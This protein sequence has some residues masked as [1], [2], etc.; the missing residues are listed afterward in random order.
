MFHIQL[1]SLL[2]ILVVYT[3]RRS[4]HSRSAVS[5]KRFTDHVSLK[6]MVQYYL[7][8]GIISRT[9]TDLYRVNLCTKVLSGWPWLFQKKIYEMKLSRFVF[10]T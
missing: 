5:S 4:F 10:Q 2:G 7:I 9:Y 6:S 8:I 3:V 1:R